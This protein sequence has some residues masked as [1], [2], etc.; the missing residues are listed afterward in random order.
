MLLTWAEFC[1][2]DGTN[3]A[4][5]TDQA[6]VEKLIASATATIEKYCSR[7][8]ESALR[9][10]DTLWKRSVCL[11]AIPVSS[12]QVFADAGEGFGPETEL[13]DGFWVDKESGVVQFA[14]ADPGMLPLRIT[15]TGGFT[16]VPED[17]KEAVFK[18]VKWDKQRI[19]TNQ[20]GIRSQ[21]SG[22][23]TTNYDTAL[24][25][26]VRQTLDLYRLA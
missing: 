18:A 16:V 12:I 20:V 2:Y 17:L 19:F 10:V 5:T 23:V 7:Q 1:S 8:F 9:S 13:A 21:I 25:Y 26:E 11:K 22:E 6:R 3:P 4:D 14:Y 15:Y 24:P